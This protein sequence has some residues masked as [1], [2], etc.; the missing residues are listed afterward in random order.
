MTSVVLDTSVLLAIINQEE[1]SKGA[2]I[3]L[4]DAVISTVIFAETIGVLTARYK[5]PKDEVIIIIKQLISDIISFDETQSIFAGELELLNK[6][7]K[8]GLSL[9]DKSCIALGMALKLPIYT[10]DKIWTTLNLENTE[11]ISIR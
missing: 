3:L 9:A 7:H 1:G 11:I 6:T 5:I 8:Y 10:A 2:S 4:H